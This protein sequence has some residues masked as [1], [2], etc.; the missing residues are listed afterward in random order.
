M[1]LKTRGRKD[2]NGMLEL[3]CSVM[4]IWVLFFIV[5]IWFREG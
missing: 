5:A 4:I 2:Y 1:K 3:L